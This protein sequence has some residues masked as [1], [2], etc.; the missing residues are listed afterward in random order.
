MNKIYMAIVIIYSIVVVKYNLSAFVQPFWFESIP[1]V[2]STVWIKNK[3]TGGDNKVKMDEFQNLVNL[4]PLD[5]G[6][7]RLDRA[8]SAEYQSQTMLLLK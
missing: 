6:F 8:V 1:D 7:E 2:E 3:D 4:W 5:S